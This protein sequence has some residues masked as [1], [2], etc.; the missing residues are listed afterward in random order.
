MEHHMSY[1]QK[2][3]G[4]TNSRINNFVADG[5]WCGVN[6]NSILHKTSTSDSPYVKLK[7]WSAPGLERP[8]F[9]EATSQ[10]FEPAKVGDSFG[11]SWSTHW[12][13]VTL[14]I[15]KELDGWVGNEIQ[16]QFNPNCESMIWT[17]DGRVVQGLAGGMRVHYPIT[18]KATANEPTRKFYIEVACNGLFGN[19]LGGDINPPNPNR[20]FTLSQA[21]LVAVDREAL[22]LLHDFN[23]I[24]RMSQELPRESPRS[25][26]A[27]KACNDIVNAF[28]KDHPEESVKAGR[29]IAA[30]YLSVKGGEG[31]HK[32]TAI[33]NCHIDT[34]WLWPYDETKRKIARSWSTQLNHLDE[35]PDFMFAASQAQQFEWLKEY[36]PELFVRVVEK[37]KTGRF[38][39][40]GA[41]WVEM[42][43]N[44]P[45][46]ESLSRQFLLGQRFFEQHFGE[47]S[48][49]FWL[50]DTFGYSSQLP[51]IVRLS[52]A[53][54]FFTQKLSWNNINVFPHTTFRWVGLDGS[55]I[56][57]HMSPTETYTASVH[58]DEVLRNVSKHKDIGYTNESLLLY[59]VGDGGG[60]PMEDHIERAIRLKDLDGM[61][62]VKH[63]HPQDFY[64]HVEKNAKELVSWK[65]ELYFEL[66]RGTYTS[67]S[68]NK[69][70]NRESEFLLR[71][72]ELL[73]V[74]AKHY[75]NADGSSLFDAHAY[76]H[77]EFTRLWKLV[78]LN[79]FHD[80]IP[81]SSIE[82]VYRDSDKMYEDILTSAR[83]IRSKA[84]QSIL[85]DGGASDSHD[86]VVVI[87]TCGWDRNEVVAVPLPPGVSN[88][89]QYSAIPKDNFHSMTNA[90][91]S[92]DASESCTSLGYVVAT[93][94]Q[95]TSIKP[96][97][98]EN[99]TEVI[100]VDAYQSKDGKAYVLENL[101]IKATFDQC[102]RL[103]S[104]ID[105]RVEREVLAG[106]SNQLQIYDDQPIFWDAWDI[107]IYH[108]EKYRNI[109]SS[110]VVSI[111]ESGP[112]V[113]TLKVDTKISDKSQLTQYISLSATSP[114]LD[115][116]NEVDWHEAHK[117]L[118]VEFTWDI[119]NDF[120]TYETQYGYIQ[121]PT[122]RNTSWDMAKFEVCGH[123]FAD[124]SEYGYGVALLNDSKYGYSTE[125]NVM[126][127]NLL[128]SPK[129]PDEHCDMGRHLFRYAVYPHIGSF[130]ESDVVPEAYKFN[131]PM[132]ACPV[133]RKTANHFDSNGVQKPME[134][135]FRIAPASSS[136]PSSS[137]NRNGDKDSVT[138]VVMD[139]IKQSEDDPN[140]IVV[141][142]YEAYGGRV[143]VHLVSNLSI[144]KAVFCNILEDPMASPD[145]Y[146]V[147]NSSDKKIENIYNEE[148]NSI[149]IFFKPFQVV[150]VKLQLSV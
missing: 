71:D 25:W 47:R 14:E 104:L 39:P 129:S 42:D 57:S 24:R 37:A 95:G 132:I 51:Q 81:G 10:E 121:R 74:V 68:N 66:H 62:Q 48:K 8:T 84:I 33:G 46:G 83:A 75:R 123:K 61:P 7:K 139:C 34:A 58:V 106:R 96:I 43:C 147:S 69:K 100:P 11:P 72:S 143:N 41:T 111:L 98:F 99:Q 70:W 18:K 38:I 117:C 138:N 140:T 55:W 20:T 2:H 15:P 124:L 135:F 144:K 91:L 29:A 149:P 31:N 79:Q 59:G 131:V 27:L 127:L 52:D 77:E 102:G 148:T 85:G 50:P 82:M 115:F 105:R 146:E 141:R 63:G 4:I 110:V 118:K 134:P 142:M 136:S 126:R 16:F 137:K 30:E 90:Y 92:S 65:G 60:G 122:H 133:S 86:S 112:L 93:N 125:G 40:V 53:K 49:I 44:I 12:L 32:I 26:Q 128:R 73:S 36:Y 130:N 45:S 22:N 109:E 120:A 9:A 5:M 23:L 150:S 76:P 80:V 64:E 35:Y 113:A 28:D 103:V 3:R 107:E 56:L 101:Y 97:G 119:T 108:L 17:E 54:Y 116:S 21:E 88:I 67:Q 6:L 94:V 145:G 1:F 87:N 78:C 13:H 19:G 89:A 114:R